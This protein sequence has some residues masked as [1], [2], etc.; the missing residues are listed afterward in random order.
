MH[1][2][3]SNMETQAGPISDEQIRDRAYDIW[4]RHHCP[5]GFEMQFWLMA[6]RELLAEREARLYGEPAPEKGPSD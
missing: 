1:K 2:P 6:K 4:E 3:P 5:E